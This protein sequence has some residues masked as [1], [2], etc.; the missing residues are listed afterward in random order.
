[1]PESPLSRYNR[2]L[3]KPEF[4]K[5]A[6]QRIAVE[7]LQRLY[8]EL[9]AKPKPSKGLWQKITGAQQTIASVKGLYFWGGVGRGKSRL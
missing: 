9:I 6:A 8:E 7:H 1:M 5:D 3:L 4:E 2:D